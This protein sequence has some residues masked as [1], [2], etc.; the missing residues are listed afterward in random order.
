MSHNSSILIG[1][2]IIVFVMNNVAHLSVTAAPSGKY[3]DRIFIMMFEN[4]WIKETIQ[5][6]YFASLLKNGT[7]LSEYHGVTHPSQPN[8]I[9]QLGGDFFGIAT[10][11]Y[12]TLN[13]TNL[14]DLMEPHGLT[15]K[16]YQENYPGN[17]F[18]GEYNN[19]LY[20]RKHNPF[21]IFENIR[22]NK[23][24]CSN[25]VNSDQLDIDIRNGQLPNL[26]YYTPNLNNDGHD[27][28]VKYAD[29]YL[30]QM[31][32]KYLKDSRFMSDRTLIFITFDEDD[33]IHDNGVYTM[34]IGSMVQKG[35]VDNTMYSHYSL[36][37]TIED[38]WNLGTLGR[39]DLKM[40]P[41]NSFVTRK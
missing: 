25:I 27:T 40:Y 38:N 11:D 4:Q 35:A 34:L 1:I 14:V 20:A 30:S 9:T 31:L 22:N 24:R 13:V 3:F 28:G 16:S 36:L 2:A 17:C 19:H 41:F 23:Q 32:P 10:D 6:P 12:V 21:I 29:E 26:M 15:W 5:Q 37:R 33:Y 18:D 8:Y 7:L 39:F